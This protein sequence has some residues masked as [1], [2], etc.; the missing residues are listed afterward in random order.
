MSE[1]PAV[2]LDIVVRRRDRLVE[3]RF[4]RDALLPVFRYGVHGLREV[5]NE[6]RIRARLIDGFVLLVLMTVCC[7]SY[8][9]RS[10]TSSTAFLGVVPSRGSAHRV[11]R[12][13]VGRSWASGWCASTTADNEWAC[14]GQP[15]AGCCA[16]CMGPRRSACSMASA[17]A[18]SLSP[19]RVPPSCR[20]DARRA[21]AS[22]QG[23]RRGHR[24]R[25]DDGE[26]ARR[27]DPR[28]C[29]SPSPWSC[30]PRHLSD[31][32]GRMSCRG[33]ARQD[34]AAASFRPRG[35]RHRP[36]AGRLHHGRR[37]SADDTASPGPT[38]SASAT[39]GLETFYAQQPQWS[40]CED[41][42]ECAKCRGSPR[43][44]RAAASPSSS[45]WSGCPAADD[46]ADRLAPGQPGRSRRLRH[47]VRARCPDTSSQAVLARFDVVGFDPRGVGR[48]RARPVPGRRAARRVHRGLTAPPT[49][50]G[51]CSAWRRARERS[52]TAAQATPA[53]LLP[54]VGTARRRPRHGRA[55][56]RPRRRE[57]HLP[58]Q[59]VRHL[60][61]RDLR[62]PLPRPRRAHSSSTAPWTRHAPARPS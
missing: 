8:R 28:R 51:R 31:E 15:R 52:P 29:S 14:L 1:E 48:V 38:A 2:R 50:R 16:S 26:R 13:T 4:L 41:G 23:D 42:F 10:A 46:G 3:A 36:R 59:V 39:H 33:G 44:R 7:A 25:T 9:H 30:V 55:A 57:A 18:R 40:D 60:P 24:R 21:P 49:R 35:L 62:R 54:H 27:V 61:R 11:E 6:D 53:T 32:R 45:P 43:L 5:R 58:R 56:R 19:R 22:R 17:P 12:L 20:H 47:R 37:P 34:G